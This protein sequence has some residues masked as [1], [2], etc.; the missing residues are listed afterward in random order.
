IKGT[1]I[2]AQTD[3][4]GNYSIQTKN[5]QTLVFSYVGFNTEE[6]IVSNIDNQLD[7]KMQMTEELMGEI[8]MVGGYSLNDN[9]KSLM[10]Y[11]E[12]NYDPEP[13]PWKQKFAKAFENQKRFQQL[14]KE[15]KKA[16]KLLKRKKRKY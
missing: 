12:T 14:K 11:K 5:N 9:S 1:R 3:F 16:A 6:I 10:G 13:A 8:I 2:G 7:L 15:R 4:D